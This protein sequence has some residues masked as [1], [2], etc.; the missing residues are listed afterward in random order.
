MCLME[1]KSGVFL[2]THASMTK[3]EDKYAEIL[4]GIQKAQKD[5]YGGP[6]FE[7][8]QRSWWNYAL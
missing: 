2:K 7:D 8:L 3:A 4:A 5:P 1:W 6:A